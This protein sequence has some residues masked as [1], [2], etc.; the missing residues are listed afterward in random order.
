MSFISLC[1]TRGK[2]PKI[3]MQ[4]AR[5]AAASYNRRRDLTRLIGAHARGSDSAIL[6]QLTFEEA[7]LDQQRRDGDADYRVLRHVDMLAAL[8]AELRPSRVL[9]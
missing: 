8:L 6:D 5:M 7:E 1:R 4:A 2:R 3:L 9:H